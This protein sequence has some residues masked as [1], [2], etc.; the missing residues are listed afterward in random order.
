ME[1]SLYR[2]IVELLL[3][4][5]IDGRF[6]P[7]RVGHLAP[8]VEMLGDGDGDAEGAAADHLSYLLLAVVLSCRR[9]AVW[10]VVA[11]E[12]DFSWKILVF[13]IVM[14]Q[15]AVASKPPRVQA[16]E[17]GVAGR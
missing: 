12:S 2:P 5:R 8:E 16:I 7:R 11:E 1:A 17:R 10:R 15:A 9:S 3:H 4:L 13:G 6:A 14:S